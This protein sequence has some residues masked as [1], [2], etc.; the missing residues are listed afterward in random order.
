MNIFADN[1][2]PSMKLRWTDFQLFRSVPRENILNSIP[3]RMFDRIKIGVNLMWPFI[4]T[5]HSSF[6]HSKRW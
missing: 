6:E 3:L 1:E 4:V 5:I 2:I